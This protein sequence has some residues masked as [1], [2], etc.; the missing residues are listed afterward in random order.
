MLLRRLLP[1]E[2]R[3]SRRLMLAHLVEVVVNGFIS[4]E[5]ARGTT[6]AA[7]RVPSGTMNATELGPIEG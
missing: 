6:R 4:N 3:Q 5:E 1:D 2:G 7:P